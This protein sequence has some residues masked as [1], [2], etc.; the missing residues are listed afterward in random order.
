MPGRPR[1]WISCC[2]G[3][4]ISR[5]SQTKRR[6]ERSRSRTSAASRSG[7]TAVSS[8]IASSTSMMRRGSANSEAVFTSVARISPLRSRMSGRAVA[9]AS[10]AGAARGAVCRAR[11]EQ[12]QPRRDHRIAEREQQDRKPDARPRLG[13]AVDVVAVEQ[14]AHEPAAPRFACARTRGASALQARLTLAWPTVLRLSERACALSDCSGRVDGF[15]ITRRSDRRCPAA[16]ASGG[17]SGSRSSSSNWRGST[18]L[19]ARWRCASAW[20]R[21]GLSSLRPFRAQRRDGVALAPDLGAQLGHALGLPRRF[22]LD[23]VDIA[24]GSDERGDHDRC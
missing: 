3:G 20:M 22:E 18:G 5:L 21:A 24:R 23:L 9:T 16:P 13:G 12:R 11:R 17:R 4:V 1:R 2:C 6:F 10:A 14:R 8:S 15:S 7:S 19:S